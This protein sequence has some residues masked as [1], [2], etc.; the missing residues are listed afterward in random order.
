MKL[1]DIIRKISEE[2][3]LDEGELR[4]RIERK[5]KEL[6][7]LITMEGAAH[8]IAN[9]VGINLFEG[10]SA[11]PELKIENIIPGMNSVDVVGRVMRIF[12]PREFEKEDGTKGK[13]CSLILGDETGT[14]RT[15]FWGKDV[16]LIEDKKIEEG[17]ILRIREGYTKENINGEPELHIGV[18][19]RVI[20][21]PKDVK[22]EDIPLPEDVK[23]KISE[24]GEGMNSVDVVCKILR[25]YEP[26]EFERDDGT[27]GKVVNLVVGDE[28][29]AGRLVLW[30]EDVGL[31]ESGRIKEGDIIKVK[32]GYVRMRFQEPEL[33]VGR[34]GKIIL[35][36]PEEIGEVPEYEPPKVERKEM[37]DLKP[38]DKAEIRGAIVE[39]Y[40]N[41]KIF[42]REEGKGIVINAVIDDGTAAMRA[43][44]YDRMAEALLNIPIKK[45]LESDV[46]DEIS[47]RRKQVL[48]REVVAMVRVIHSDFSGREELIVD[49]INLNPDPKI[50]V[51]NLLKEAKL[52]EKEE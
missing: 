45:I 14:I 47:E 39:M 12:E 31:V 15:V 1:E 50:E 22:E 33:N 5:Q 25:I 42:D 20:P 10:I 8:I 48:G 40:E 43:A 37:K 23:K 2:S 41:L 3:G 32:K 29:G 38:G 46:S 35:N 4:E 28:T 49:D 9:E 7:G 52:R 26:R 18:R 30:D 17:Q 27:K 34:Y 21:N 51:E 24:L 19:T 11:R 13:V 16:N 36:P 44:F 6:G